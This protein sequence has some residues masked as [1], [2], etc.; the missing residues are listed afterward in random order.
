MS[1]DEMENTDTTD[2]T[3]TQRERDKKAEAS[4]LRRRRDRALQL[5]CEYTY[6]G[7]LDEKHTAEQAAVKTVTAARV[8]ELYLSGE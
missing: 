6:D 7:S 4:R 1:E 3:C 8:F 2:L 5:A